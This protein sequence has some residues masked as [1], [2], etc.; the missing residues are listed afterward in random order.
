MT[1]LCSP[2]QAP[3]TA[4]VVHHQMGSAHARVRGFFAPS[5]NAG[6]FVH[7]QLGMTGT[8][9]CVIVNI[10]QG[11]FSGRHAASEAVVF[12]HGNPGSIRDWESLARGVAGFARALAMDMPGFGTADKPEEPH[13]GRESSRRA[14]PLFETMRK[15]QAG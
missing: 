7:W 5:A 4:E 10:L 12:I 14:A 2:R 3:R 6:L 15:H 11:W 8:F 9:A 1:E 13:S